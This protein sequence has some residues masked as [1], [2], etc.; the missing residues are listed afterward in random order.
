MG[1]GKNIEF[2]EIAQK[3]ISNIEDDRQQIQ[4]R[5][6]ELKNEVNSLN[7]NRKELIYSKSIQKL[8]ESLNKNNDYLIKILSIIDKRTPVDEEEE[9]DE[10]TIFDTLQEEQSEIM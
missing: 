9:Y 1:K 5:I 6:R 2:E 4:D 7:E 10:E 8:Y 3:A